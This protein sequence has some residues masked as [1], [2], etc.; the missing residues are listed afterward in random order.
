MGESFPWFLEVAQKSCALGMPL[1][2]GRSQFQRWPHQHSIYLKQV[3][4]Q[5]YARGIARFALAEPI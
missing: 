5:A 4:T 2:A 3:S 1:Y